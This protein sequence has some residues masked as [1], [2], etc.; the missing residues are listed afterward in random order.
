MDAVVEATPG[1]MPKAKRSQAKR[2]QSPEIREGTVELAVPTKKA[3]AMTKRSKSD[4]T[5][6]TTYTL[7]TVLDNWSEATDYGLSIRAMTEKEQE[8][9][10]VL[11]KGTTQ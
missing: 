6:G 7:Q 1:I 8:V 3:K 4:G 2:K 11:I 5:M 9:E 10:I